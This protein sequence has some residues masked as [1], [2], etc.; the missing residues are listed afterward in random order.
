MEMSLGTLYLSATGSTGPGVSV[1]IRVQHRKASARTQEN[2]NIPSDEGEVFAAIPAAG[3]PAG[4]PEVTSQLAPT[5]SPA[6]TTEAATEPSIYAATPPLAPDN[7]SPGMLSAPMPINSNATV[8]TGRRLS[9]IFGWNNCPGGSQS[10]NYCSGSG[11]FCCTATT[12]GEVAAA[13]AATPPP[14]KLHLNRKAQLV[15]QLSDAQL[16]TSSMVLA[17]LWGPALELDW[18]VLVAYLLMPGMAGNGSKGNNPL[19]KIK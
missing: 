3:V 18:A 5:T 11:Q 1:T 9:S 16:V 8:G 19:A 7:L 4:A 14:P 6:S 15:A 2:G 17:A 13:A 12:K 10:W